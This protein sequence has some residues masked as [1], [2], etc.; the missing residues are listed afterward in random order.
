MHGHGTG[1]DVHFEG[2]PRWRW[3]WTLLL[4]DIVHTAGSRC[5]RGAGALDCP[6][7]QA[8]NSIDSIQS[9]QGSL[10]VKFFE[11]VYVAYSVCVC[12]GGTG[13]REG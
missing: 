10:Q 5:G 13:M 6:P 9:S 1:D 2:R 3:G 12:T 4:Q 11:P 8:G 7:L